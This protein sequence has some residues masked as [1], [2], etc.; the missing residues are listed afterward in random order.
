MPLIR[1]DERSDRGT[2]PDRMPQ[3]RGVGTGEEFAAPSAR[4][5]LEGDN[6]LARVGGEE[7]ALML[8]VSGLTAS[9]R[10]RAWLGRNGFGVGV[11]RTG[12]WRRIRGRLSSGGEFGFELSEA[13][14]EMGKDAA[15]DRLKLRW[16]GRPLFGGDR[17][18]H[19]GEVADFRAPGKA[20]F[21]NASN[22]SGERLR[23]QRGVRQQVVVLPGAVRLPLAEH[24]QELG[25]VPC[26]NSRHWLPTTRTPERVVFH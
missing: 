16:E 23:G 26:K 25:H 9:L 1:G 22:P 18:R 17:R 24:E 19:A 21:Q 20:K 12:R 7:L 15:A 11:L 3:R 8:G 13:C 10:R 6:G 2:F 14:F 5:G 4:F